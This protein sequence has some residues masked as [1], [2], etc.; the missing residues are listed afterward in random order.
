MS[1]RYS[2]QARYQPGGFNSGGSMSS[3]GGGYGG[4]DY[5][6]ANNGGGNS[7]LAPLN[8]PSGAANSRFGR[9]AQFGMAGAQQSNNS[10]VMQQL[11]P[12]SNSQA[13]A[14]VTGF[15]RHKY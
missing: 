11:P 12:K 1:C 5:S 15:G 3:A 4:G 14:P 13:L 7:S 8:A 2:K 10:S 9:L 6:L